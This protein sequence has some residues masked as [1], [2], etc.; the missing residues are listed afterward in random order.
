M[1]YLRHWCYLRNR[2]EPLR[3]SSLLLMLAGAV[4]NGEAILETLRAH[5]VE[6]RGEWREA[7]R[8]LR[9]LLETGHSLSSALSLIDGFMPPATIAAFAG[10]GGGG[11]L[12]DV[13]IDEAQLLT[14]RLQGFGGVDEQ[15]TSLVVWSG[16]VLAVF[17]GVGT[18]TGIH[19]SPKAKVIFQGFGLEFPPLSRAAFRIWDNISILLPLLV[20]PVTGVIVWVT[21][22]IWKNC[23]RQQWL[24]YFPLFCHW[25][26]Y[27]TPTILRLVGIGISTG[28][29]IPGIL[30]AAILMLPA[31]RTV[32][33]VLAVRDEVQSG[34]RLHEAL[35]SSGLIRR[36][37]RH[38]LDTASER[39]HADWGFRQLALS[40]EQA[41]SR[42]MLW[43]SGLIRPSLTV[44]FGLL[45]LYYCLVVFQM[46][47]ALLEKLA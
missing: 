42:R 8:Q 40:L 12:A 10:A 3:Q 2:P 34:G 25:P 19:L 46:L 5:E 15:L 17:F 35:E 18:Y 16:A 4:G 23:A 21:I 38:F 29:T 14:V 45:V 30:N 24:G 26:R 28:S 27:W 6:S 22:L 39:G 36:S 32:T 7:V 41:R 20:L 11:G 43:I 13:L 37:E 9:T 33:R 47:I 44:G 31:G 1:S